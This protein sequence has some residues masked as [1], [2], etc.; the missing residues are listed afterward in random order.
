MT[1]ASSVFR[2]GSW[3][4]LNWLLI[5]L[6]PPSL[7]LLP[8]LELLLHSRSLTISTTMK[9]MHDANYC[10]SDFDAQK[11]LFL[12]VTKE[13]EIPI[14]HTNTGINIIGFL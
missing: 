7:A 14:K 8:L 3:I 2:A 13:L 1:E 4:V 6:P 11:Q 9:I 10:R 5:M 12:P